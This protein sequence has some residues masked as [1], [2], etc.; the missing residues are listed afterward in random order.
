VASAAGNLDVGALVGE[1]VSGGVGGAILAVLFGVMKWM[2][3]PPK[4]T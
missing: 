2:I 1:I 4:S 3:V